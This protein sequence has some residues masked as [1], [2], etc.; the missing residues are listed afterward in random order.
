M[1]SLPLLG[2]VWYWLVDH[3]RE[4]FVW[5]ALVTLV[6]CA[7]QFRRARTTFGRLAWLNVGVVFL[8][9][10]AME[11][12]LWLTVP[13]PADFVKGLRPSEGWVSHLDYGY[14]PATPSITHVAKAY[15]GK[16]I[17]DVVYTI[18]EY[19]M[20]KS[21]PERDAG[22]RRGCVLFFGCSKTF[23]EGVQ[24]DETSPWQLGIKTDGRFAVRNMA[25]QGWGPHQMLSALES[26][27][28]ERRAHCEVTEVVYLALYW[29]ALRAAGR[30]FWDPNGP[31]YV[32]DA[33]GRAVR[34]GYFSDVKLRGALPRRL[35]DRLSKSLVYKKYFAQHLDPY[36][37]PV[38]PADV[39]LFAAV[40]DRVHEEITQ[41]FPRASFHVLFWDMPLPPQWTADFK[42][43]IA[44]PGVTLHMLSE[45]MPDYVV[46]FD[47]R[48]EISPGDRHPTPAAYERI[49]D[50]VAKDVLHD[51]GP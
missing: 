27:E 44:K 30:A 16:R 20:R 41:R 50:Y 7:W 14:A 38:T 25:F 18:D 19:G 9:L 31:R 21:P 42:T 11:V 43:R 22:E 8:V 48:Y 39:A 3:A 33:S 40:I 17:Y 29:H 13:P 26:G 24:D 2:L 51:T 49:A 32:L 47:S 45:A 37:Y 1:L 10:G 5:G 12:W 6:V 46:A 36:D 28:A 34:A 23:G 15:Q 35:L 4:P